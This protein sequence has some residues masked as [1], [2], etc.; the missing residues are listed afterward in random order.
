MQN[1]SEANPQNFMALLVRNNINSMHHRGIAEQIDFEVG[2]V[3]LGPT[4][5]AAVGSNE[6]RHSAWLC[7]FAARQS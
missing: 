6:K 5:K 7:L 2:K 4:L 1:I 3:L